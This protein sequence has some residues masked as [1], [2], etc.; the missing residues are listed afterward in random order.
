MWTNM[1]WI[2]DKYILQLWFGRA[3]SNG[4][5]AEL[6]VAEWANIHFIIRT[7]TIYNLNKYIFKFGQIYF[8]F[9]TNIFSMWFGRAYPMDLVQS[10]WWV[11]RSAIHFIIKTN[12]IYNLNKYIFQFG[13]IYF[14]FWTSTFCNGDLVGL[15]QWTW[16][17][18]TGGWVGQQIHFITKTNTI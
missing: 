12:T 9:W 15:I 16:C 1:L 8:E 4:L 17:R 10:Y 7:N 6:L 2:L 11:S 14:E 18:V 5:G 13:Q 3:Y